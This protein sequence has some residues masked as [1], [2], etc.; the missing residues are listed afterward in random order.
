MR[1]EFAG[2]IW[3]WRG[4]SPFH[5]VPV[6][7]AESAEIRAVATIVTY[8]WGV[9]PVRVTIGGT[10]FDTSLFPKDGRYLVPLKDAVRRAEGLARGD[11]VTVEL[12]IRSHRLAL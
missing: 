6:P 12:A 2:E 7:E 5:F 4:P 11:V 1:F 10:T 9:I 3:Y 8:G